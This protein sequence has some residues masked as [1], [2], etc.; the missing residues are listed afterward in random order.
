MKEQI[1]VGPQI[2]EVFK[3]PE[4]EKTLNTLELRVWH[5][6][7]WICSNFLGNFKSNSYR[8]GVAELLAAYKEMGCRMSLNMHFLHSHFDFQENLGAVSDEQGERFHQY[9]QATEERYKGVWNEGMI[10]DYRWMLYRDDAN[11]PY[12]RISYFEHF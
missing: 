1:F 6:F 11:Y 4:F 8:E 3:D 5:A 10:G 7:E 2:R 9:I 12:K